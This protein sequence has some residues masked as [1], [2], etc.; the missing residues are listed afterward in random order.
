MHFTAPRGE[1]QISRLNLNKFR[2][3]QGGNVRTG[4]AMCVGSQLTRTLVDMRTGTPI[5]YLA[6]SLQLQ[7]QS[8]GSE[9]EHVALEQLY[10][11]VSRQFNDGTP[12]STLQN[13]I[14]YI[15]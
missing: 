5:N 8:R 13:R 2:Y 11:R 1:P 7:I 12:S 9:T 14:A 4:G 3:T 6:K 10:L 15:H